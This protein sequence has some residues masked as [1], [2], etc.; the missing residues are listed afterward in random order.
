MPTLQ[1]LRYLVAV[2]DTLSFSRAAL[3]C[4]V[5]QPTLS[6][7]LKELEGRLNAQ[8]VERTRARVLLTPAGKDIAQRARRVL[9]DID[10][11]R[12]VARHDDLNPLE[13]TLQMGVV[14]TVG[15][16]VLSVAMPS[17][18]A[19]FP[20]L[21]I[22]VREDR[23]ENLPSKLSDGTHDLLLLPEKIA[24]PDF[25][26]EQLIREPLQLVMP[27]DHRLANLEVVQPED[28]AGETILVMEQGRRLHDEI[29]ALCNEFGAIQAQDF[30]GT[31]LDTLRLMVTTGMGL[32]LLPALYVRSDILRETLIV[33]RPLARK[34]PVRDV[35]M[36]WRRSSPLGGAYRTLAT[37][38]AQ[39]L[40]PWTEDF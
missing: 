17:L 29:A 36:A 11:I 3:A 27:A 39:S 26:S 34:A 13:G 33:A 6:L 1:Q 14:Q 4:H 22:F 21:R 15:A 9:A 25:T 40:T 35:T 12:E 38:I 32:S 30:A 2:A 19:K 8:L 20:D 37:T 23:F 7:Q 10:D 24:H 18:R 16:Y 5:T 28:I 31:T